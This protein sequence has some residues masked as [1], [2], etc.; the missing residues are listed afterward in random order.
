MEQEIQA[1]HAQINSLLDLRNE[2]GD[3]AVRE[4]IDGRLK[5]LTHRLFVLEA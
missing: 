2:F 4:Q 1:I 3:D 5:K